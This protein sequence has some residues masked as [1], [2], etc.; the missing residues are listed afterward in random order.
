MADLGLCIGERC[1]APGL[2]FDEK[3]QQ[4][5]T[6]PKPTTTTNS[7]VAATTAATASANKQAFTSGKGLRGTVIASYFNDDKFSQNGILPFSYDMDY[8]PYQ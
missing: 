3:K 2:A 4:C 6:P 8:A 1:C 5:V 7:I